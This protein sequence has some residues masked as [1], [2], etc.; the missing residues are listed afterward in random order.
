MAQSRS[1]SL[2]APKAELITP[3]VVA[4]RDTFETM[5]GMK[6]HRKNLYIKKGSRM[7][8]EISGIIGLSGRTTGTCAI[9]LPEMVAVAAIQRLLSAASDASLSRA[10]LHDGVGELINMI[11][12]RAK[13]LLSTTQYKFDISLPTIV[14]GEEHEFYQKKTALCV[15]ILFETE[16]GGLFTLEVTVA[17]R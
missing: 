10:D 1:Q 8:G 17:A 3:F 2:S 6:V 13:A 14:S 16:T 15:V 9:S 12:G 11:V 7:Y 5:L 4:V